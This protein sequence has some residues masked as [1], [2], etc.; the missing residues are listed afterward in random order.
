MQDQEIPFEQVYDAL[1]FR[2][3]VDDVK[4][5]YE[6]LGVCLPKVVEPPT[7]VPDVVE[8]NDIPVVDE[9]DDGL[10]TIG[11][12]VHT[13]SVNIADF[14]NEEGIVPDRAF[15]KIRFERRTTAPR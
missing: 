6:A 13:Q 7:P 14:L 3:L 11:N 5:C 2:I 9:P 15:H 8:P 1:A 12:G 4:S 10:L